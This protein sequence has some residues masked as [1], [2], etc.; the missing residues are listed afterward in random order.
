MIWFIDRYFLYAPGIT[1]I[2]S[3]VVVFVIVILFPS[4]SVVSLISVFVLVLLFQSVSVEAL[5]SVCVFLSRNPMLF[6]VSI[7]PVSSIIFTW[8]VAGKHITLELS[9]FFIT[10]LLYLLVNSLYLLK[11]LSYDCPSSLDIST[12]FTIILLLSESILIVSILLSASISIVHTISLL[13]LF[14]ML[15]IT[16]FVSLVPICL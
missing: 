4:L 2:T 16:V 8:V 12:F 10:V 9:A 11:Q 3:S 1:V 7:S 14:N 13:S 5:I 15:L 6:S